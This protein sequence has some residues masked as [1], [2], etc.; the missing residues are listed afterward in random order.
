MSHS[1]KIA[2]KPRLDPEP[3]EIQ[4]LPE[5]KTPVRPQNEQSFLPYKLTR[6]EGLA[7]KLHEWIQVL[8]FKQRV[9]VP[10]PDP[11]SYSAVPR[12][13]SPFWRRRRQQS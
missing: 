2:A 3:R 13:V 11:F 12:T 8:E 7:M 6:D 5:E 4:M 1:E 10:L 9:I